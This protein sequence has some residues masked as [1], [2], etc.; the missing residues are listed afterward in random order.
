MLATNWD[1]SSEREPLVVKGRRG[2]TQEFL[3]EAAAVPQPA[4]P[5]NG[6][7]GLDR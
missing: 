2:G 6:L 5:G 1:R 3:G 4:G 7:A